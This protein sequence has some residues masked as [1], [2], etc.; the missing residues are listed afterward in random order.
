MDA[1]VED[2]CA[3]R[4]VEA[5]GLVPPRALREAWVAV[6]RG[7]GDLPGVLERAGQLEAAQAAT[8]RR[9]GALLARVEAEAGQALALLE[10]G[11]PEEDLD[12]LL[13]Q[14]ARGGYRRTLAALVP[15]AWAGQMPEPRPRRTRHPVCSAV[16]TN[17]S[18]NPIHRV[19]QDLPEAEVVAGRYRIE[20]RVGSGAMGDV[21]RVRHVVTE[22]PL[23]LK[24]VSAGGEQEKARF[25]REARSLGR[26]RHRNIVQVH[27]AGEAGP[28]ILYMALD[29]IDGETL[30]ERV[31]REGAL[32]LEDVYGWL[33]EIL[34]ALDHAHDLG[35][36]H[37]DL[38]GDNIMLEDGGREASA[39][40]ILDFGV[41]KLL[42][43]NDRAGF[44]TIAGQL[45][46]TPAYM[47]PEQAAGAEVGPLSDLYSVGV[48]AYEM[49]TARLPFLSPTSLGFLGQHMAQVPDSPCC[50]R[51]DLPQALAGWI[52]RLLEK[53]PQARFSSARAALEALR[54]VSLD[55]EP[56]PAWPPLA[57]PR[58]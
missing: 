22:R 41:A 26:L 42:G 34:S 38:K 8:L 25:L 10:S 56:E 33:L 55:A 37:R 13:R 48:L 19:A 43:K 49:V 20:E 4:V 40:K 30:S 6:S 57:L 14:Q 2:L 21:Y 47:S 52:L 54:E 16:G 28:D 31:E 35:V 58:L 11:F 23:A 39:V 45:C 44:Q 7:E 1:P 24:L 46:G 53:E 27:D 9:A 51:E 3:A 36:V 5:N 29:F 50:Y 15:G 17:G 32:D 12:E 18:W